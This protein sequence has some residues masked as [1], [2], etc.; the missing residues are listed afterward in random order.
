MSYQLTVAEKSGFEPTGNGA[1]AGLEEMTERMTREA[2]EA[3][4]QAV[5]A[6]ADEPAVVTA[7][8]TTMI[9]SN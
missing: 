2:V 6:R 5:S 1:V 9:E 3:M 8:S 7:P 4:Q